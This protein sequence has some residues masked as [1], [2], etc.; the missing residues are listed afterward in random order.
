MLEDMRLRKLAPH[1]QA[2]YVRAVRRLAGY[3][4]HPPDTA[5]V[6]D[7][8]NFQ[9][10]LVDRGTSPITLSATIA[11]LRFFFDVTLDR[12]ECACNPPRPGGRGYLP[13][14][15]ADFAASPAWSLESWTTQGSA[16]S[17]SAQRRV[18]YPPC[19]RQEPSRRFCGACIKL[20]MP[21]QSGP[22]G[23]RMPS[24]RKGGP[25]R[26]RRSRDK[27]DIS[28]ARRTDRQGAAHPP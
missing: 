18:P 1:T 23:L 27:R 10:N 3:L 12:S 2:S 28:L 14:P 13:R 4:R 5:T 11:G 26:A 22:S 24:Q 25:W 17:S 21:Q 15:R 19:Q 16:V 9:L 7:L 8:R 6:E 20:H